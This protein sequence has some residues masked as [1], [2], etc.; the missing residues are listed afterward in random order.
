MTHEIDR[1]DVLKIACTT[2]AAGA[3]GIDAVAEATQAKKILGISCSPRKGKTTAS[4][5]QI[6]LDAAKEYAPQ[7]ETEFMDLAEM[8]I[9]AYIAAGLPLRDGDK[10]DF[11]ALLPRLTDPS[12]IGVI[13]GSPVYFG[14]M[15]ALCKC[16]LDRC[17][18]IRSDGFKW[19]NKAGG[20][21]AVGSTRNGGQE[22]T[23]ESIKT[24]LMG[25]D[26]L[27]VGTGHPSVRIGATLWNQDD[28][29]AADEF[30]ISTAKDL[31]RRV[32]E[33]ALKT[34]T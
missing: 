16:F 31:G 9:P 17:M 2:L 27:L 15:S 19:R 7:I 23:I 26:M 6:S 10:D 1:R 25:Q 20:A 34:W 11:P 30:G 33:L 24:A 8:N 22:L 32:T 13:I 21:I 4:A 3:L 28:S 18:A 29:I 14:N 12:V 5:V